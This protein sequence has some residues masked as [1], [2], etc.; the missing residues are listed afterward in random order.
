[1]IESYLKYLID[2]TQM[3]DGVGREIELIFQEI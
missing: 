3:K 2:Y 1:M